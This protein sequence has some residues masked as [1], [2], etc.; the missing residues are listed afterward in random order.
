[1]SSTISKAQE[2]AAGL[3]AAAREM[4][5]RGAPGAVPLPGLTPRAARAVARILRRKGIAAQKHVVRL[6]GAPEKARAKGTIL[7]DGEWT[8][9]SS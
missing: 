3:E 4:Q 5:M 1:M 9:V 6:D 2:L 7:I 8:E